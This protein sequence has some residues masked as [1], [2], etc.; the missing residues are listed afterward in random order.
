MS[1][2]SNGSDGSDSINTKPKT[3]REAAEAYLEA[4]KNEDAK[5]LTKLTK[6]Y[7]DMDEAEREETEE[8][9]KKG[10]EEHPAEL[11]AMK[12]ASIDGVKLYDGWAKVFMIDGDGERFKLKFV[13]EEDGV[14]R[15]GRPEK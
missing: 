2:G 9:Y 6:G 4:I 7:I 1:C 14:W 15:E 5:A 12:S 10:F 11:K 3:P 8:M 13:K